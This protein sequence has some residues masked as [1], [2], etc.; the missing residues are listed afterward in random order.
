[1][2]NISIISK[3][4]NNCKYCFQQDSYHDLNMMLSYDD[5]DDIL[6]WS[7]GTSRIA[8]LGGEP[9]LHPDIVRIV[10]RCVSEFPVVIFSNLLCKTEILEKILSIGPNIGWLV[11]TTTR[12]ELKDLFEKNMKLFQ[13]CKKEMSTGITL[14]MDEEY[15]NRSIENMVRLGKEYPDVVR[16]YRLGLATPFH[17]NKVELLCYDEPV[18]RFCELAKKETPNISIGFDCPTNNCQITP[19][20][21][22]KLIE[23]YRVTQIHMV[24]RCAPIFDVMVDKSIKYCSSVPDDFI[25]IKH[26]REFRNA[27]ECETF[28]LNFKN[29]YLQ[30]NGLSCMLEKR[31]CVNEICCGICLAT[32]EYMR[33]QRIEEK[34]NADKTTA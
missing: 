13:K 8:L 25:P 23:D 31:D 20:T 27:R 17:K 6:K 1:M 24:S 15:D 26:Y 22:A 5:I 18:L 29:N 14:M 9:T 19:K 3:C 21:M 2:V 34:N 16:H 4:N 10:Q 33:R 30:Q 11:N 28:L 12:D 32:T 7:K